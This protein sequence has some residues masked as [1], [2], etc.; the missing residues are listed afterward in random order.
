MN[1][2]INIKLVRHITLSI[3][4]GNHLEVQLVNQTSFLSP[5]MEIGEHRKLCI[6]G[7]VTIVR[8]NSLQIKKTCWGGE[9]SHP[10]SKT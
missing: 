7:F 9:N 2:I 10:S 5:Q 4:M 8:G 6:H 1:I 3:K